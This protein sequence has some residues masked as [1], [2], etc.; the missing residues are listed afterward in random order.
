MITV[1]IDFG[2]HQTKVC[3]EIK[4]AGTA[5]YNVIRFARPDGEE[6][7]TLPSFV[8]CQWDGTLL[9]G[10]EAIS[11]QFGGKSITYFKQRMFDRS[12]SCNRRMEAEQWSVLYLAYLIFKLDVKLGT[13]RYVVH[14]GMPTC[15]DPTFYNFAKCQ[16]IKVMAAAMLIAR[17]I[18]GN[19]LALYLRTPYSK[20]IMEANRAMASIPRDMHEA[21]RKFPIFV[22]PEAYVALIPLIAEHRLPNVGPNLFVDIGGGTVD[23]SFFTNQMAGTSRGNRPQLYYYS[24]VPCGLNVITGQD[25]LYSHT[26]E[27][28]DELI[29][30]WGVD[31]FR[32]SLIKAID[33]LM[34][35]LRGQYE[36]QDLI[37]VMPFMNLCEQILDGRPI[38]YSG[39]G[40]IFH[41]LRLSVESANKNCK[42]R[43][44]QVMTVSELVAHDRLSIDDKMFHVLAT[45][46]ALSH[47]SLCGYGAEPDAIELVEL[48]NL[49]G[50]IALPHAARYAP[51]EKWARPKRWD[52]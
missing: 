6:T 33:D 1:G 37:R 47:Q 25:V 23:I 49:L 46:F 9:Y 3:C 43:F 52:W 29:T 11:L 5:L 35:I 36:N 28:T 16:A 18:F 2:T 31:R 32:Q 51:R 30:S 27:V 8:H 50:G 26:V 21:R 13:Q 4:E 7:P 12:L 41:R 20:L 14:M 34:S 40:S 48:N 15:A 39:G 17:K 44:S 19:D 10:H 42:Y 38:C 45:A 22:F 24:S